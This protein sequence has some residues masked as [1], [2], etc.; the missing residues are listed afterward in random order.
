MLGELDTAAGHSVWDK[1]S[2]QSAENDGSN[3]LDVAYCSRLEFHFGDPA[4]LLS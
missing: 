1:I 2:S 4:R 3:A